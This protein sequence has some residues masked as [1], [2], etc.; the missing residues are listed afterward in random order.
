MNHPR[1]D[2]E[3]ALE[4]AAIMLLADLGWLET[5]NAY[6]E[7]HQSELATERQPYLG[8]DS[9]GEVVLVERLRIA[10]ERL[11][12]DA[13]AE[14]LTAAIADITRPRGA[15]SPVAANQEI[16]HLLRHGCRAAY[17][18]EH[19]EAQIVTLRLIDWQTPANNDFLLISQLWITGDHHTRRTDLL[20][21]V[22]GLPLLFIELKSGQRRLENAHQDNLRDYRDTIPHL[23]WYNALVILSN[24]LESRVGSFNT[25]WGHFAEWK[26][27]NSEGEAGAI[28]LETTL[29]ATCS[30][31]RLLDLVENFTLFIHGK[32]GLE[33]LVAKNHQYLGVNNA[34]AQVQQ[35]DHN[36]GRLGVFWHTQG[37]GKSYS[38]L[39]FAEKVLRTLPGNWTFLIVTDR[40]ELDKQI[41]QNFARAGVVTEPEKSVRAQSSQHL[42]TLLSEDHR[43]LFTL[44]HK[45]RIEPGQTYPTL[46]N[47]ADIIVMVD[48][49]HRTQY[50][51]LA[52]NMRNAL[53]NAAF[54]AFTGTPLIAGEERTK[55][56]FGDYVSV[57]NFQQSIQDEA[58]VPLYYE[59]RIPEV[60]LT[61]PNLNQEMARLL[62]EAEL[63]E[64]QERRLERELARE[65]HLITRDERLDK[66][67]EDIVAHF[68]Q[69]GHRGK[70]MVVCIDK[71]TAVKMYAKVQ[72]H[73]RAS[74]TRYQADLRQAS[75]LERPELESLVAFMQETDM[76]VVVSQAQNEIDDF[77]RKG[78][79][80]EPHRQRMNN[81]DLETHFKDPDHPLRLVFVCAMWMTGFD[82]PACSTIYLDKPMRNHTLMQTIARANRV[83]GE[84]VNGLI[85][86]YIGIFRDLQ[87]ALAIYGTGQGHPGSDDQPVEDKAVLVELLAEAITALLDFCQPLGVD[88]PAIAAETDTFRRLKQRADAVEAL[89]LADD[90]KQAF[91]NLADDVKRLYKAILPD[92]QAKTH[93]PLAD[94]AGVL[95]QQI[96]ATIAPA[97]ISSIMADVEALLDRSIAAE[98]YIIRDSPV[99][100]QTSNSTKYIDLGQL[101]IEA[102]RQ[103]FVET[104]HKRTL[105][106]RLRAATSRKLAQLV[107]L[108]PH[109][110]DYAERFRQLIDEYN[111]GSKNIEQFHQELLDFISDLSVEETRHVKEGLT[112][113]EL[114]LFDL[115]TKP[116]VKLT[117]TERTQVK[118]AARE[119]LNVLI[120]H[121][122]ILDWKKQQRARA[123]VRITIEEQ[124]DALLPPPYNSELFQQKC[125]AVY[126]HIFDNYQG[127]GQ[128]VYSMGVG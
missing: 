119:L 67:A 84:K 123:A 78:Y 62:D 76:A 97:D 37:S 116:A 8:R 118:N 21:F 54:I 115:L 18:D 58:T 47:R 61:N 40:R 87:K 122:L 125:D 20:G 39:F 28:S 50:D 103:T 113:E 83:F 73:W 53:P 95:A 33:K 16:Y 126:Q 35:I 38:M 6:H 42:Q 107:R 4:Q 45:F 15:M 90:T 99:A 127:N 81:E 79:D 71:L 29:R 60:Q 94:L 5:V 92:P 25:P 128:S 77:R 64:A 69:R 59:N 74:L 112:E 41:Y 19:N 24:G 88:L 27:I 26:R 48:E 31:A 110:V 34:L 80:I 11:N 23:F 43:Y 121:K 70:G 63:D 75:E 52:L 46:T 85:V 100:Y 106:E 82:A 30:P 91:L 13:P 22:N 111:A 117:K 102:L 56:V 2:S 10:L 36:Q 12:P 96:R 89:L 109:R 86:D 72:T 57:Y 98:G 55:E 9:R 108:N 66:I 49:A 14:A 114:A 93:Q 101:D 104:P 124:L 68:G 65:Y 32:N 17:Q 44:I 51:V 105:T 3:D 120:S 1:P 7:V